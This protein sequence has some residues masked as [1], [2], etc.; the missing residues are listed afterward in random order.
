M[1]TH[2]QLKILEGDTTYFILTTSDGM[3]YFNN[4]T[5]V[6]R[7]CLIQAA[8]DNLLVDFNC[9]PS[10]KLQLIQ[11]VLNGHNCVKITGIAVEYYMQA[12][13]GGQKRTP[14][15]RRVNLPWQCDISWRSSVF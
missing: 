12:T 4:I 5:G 8:G 14:R 6:Y 15:Y 3:Y 2:G 13:G 7:L 9:K 11:Q 1:F 10:G